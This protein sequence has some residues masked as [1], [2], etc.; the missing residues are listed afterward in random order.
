MNRCAVWRWAGPAG[1]TEWVHETAPSMAIGCGVS[2]RKRRQTDEKTTVSMVHT[3]LSKRAQ[4]L[5]RMGAWVRSRFHV[6]GE[7]FAA[8][9]YFELRTARWDGGTP[10]QGCWSIR[11]TVVAPRWGPARAKVLAMRALPIVGYVVLSRRTRSPT[12]SGKG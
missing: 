7:G 6:Q 12:K 3:V 5:D 2:L 11:P 9:V 8:V 4:T 1:R 10:A